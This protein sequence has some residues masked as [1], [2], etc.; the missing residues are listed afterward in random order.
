MFINVYQSLADDGSPVACGDATVCHTLEDAIEDRDTPA[1]G[2]R[3]LYTMEAP[4]LLPRPDT[5]DLD[6]L[7]REQE[8]DAR[9]ERQHVRGLRAGVG[10]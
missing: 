8:A 7:W 9:L 5:V 4:V 3:Y 6:E 1:K 2:Y 10:R